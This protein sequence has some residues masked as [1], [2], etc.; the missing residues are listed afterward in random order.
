[1]RNREPLVSAFTGTHGS[2]MAD[3]GG[4]LDASGPSLNQGGPVRRAD[5]FLTVAIFIAVV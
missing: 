4:L 5:R 1:V 2:S 3:S